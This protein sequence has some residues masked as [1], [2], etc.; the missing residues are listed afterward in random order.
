MEF[1]DNVPTDSILVLGLILLFLSS[2]FASS[3]DVY[4]IVIAFWGILLTAIGI[5]CW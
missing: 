5:I 2:W 1:K 4:F 3:N